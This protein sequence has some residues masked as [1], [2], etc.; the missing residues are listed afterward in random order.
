MNSQKPHIGLF[1]PCYVD[2]FYP[3][4]GIAT[5]ELLEKFGCQVS[6]PLDQTCCGQ[7]MANAGYERDTVGTSER[8]IELFQEYDYVVAPSGSC[9]LHVK[10]HFP[11]I[12]GKEKAQKA[13]HDKIFEL[14]EFLTDILKVKVPKGSFPHRVGYHASCHGQRGLRLASSSEMNITPFNKA[15]SLLENLE[16]LEWVEL[17]RSDECCGFGGTFAVTEEALSLQ[18]GKDRL[19]DHLSHDVEILTGG[20][21]SCI[22][23]LQ[24]IASREGRKLKFM[25]VAEILNQAIQ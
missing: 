8:F 3:E 1:I 23:H 25:H 22:M 15:K 2:Q 19:D 18:M 24:G 14:T 5:L 17:S 12:S 4:V 10:E 13:I 21:M 11:V 16:G 9:V 7:P 6:Y 20:D